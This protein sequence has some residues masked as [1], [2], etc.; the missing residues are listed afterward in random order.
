MDTD[1]KPKYLEKDANMIEVNQWIKQL[2][3][4]I[5][6]GYRSIPPL[7]GIYMHLGPLIHESWSTALKVKDPEVA[8]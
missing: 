4:H 6:V 8:T 5:N 7:T 1:L 3:N 2:T